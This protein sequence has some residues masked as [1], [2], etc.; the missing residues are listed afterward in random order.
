MDNWAYCPHCMVRTYNELEDGMWRC[1][2]CDQYHIRGAK[3]A[4]TVDRSG[5][6]AEWDNSKRGIPVPAAD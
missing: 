1:K 2:T 4:S 5:V 3:V 6:Y